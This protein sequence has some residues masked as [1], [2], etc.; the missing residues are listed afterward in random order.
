MSAI[1]KQVMKDMV[2]DKLDAIKTYFS[3]DET[4]TEQQE[5]AP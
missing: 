1:K 5:S 3:D 2:K 4:E